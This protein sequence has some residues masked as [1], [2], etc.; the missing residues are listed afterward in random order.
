MTIE[1]VVFDRNRI[2]ARGGWIELEHPIQ[3]AFL[4]DGRLFVLFDPDS[5]SWPS[6]NMICIGLNG[7]RLWVAEF[8]ERTREDYYYLISSR[9]PL[10]VTSFSSY[11]CELDPETGKIVSREFFK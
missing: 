10:V 2:K 9:K 5:G 6:A 3:D 11:D 1:E 7:E 8:P 4:E